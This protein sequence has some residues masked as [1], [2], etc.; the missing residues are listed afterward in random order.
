M[1]SGLGLYIMLGTDC[2]QSRVGYSL[3]RLCI[4]WRYITIS[5]TERLFVSDGRSCE[6]VR[7]MEFFFTKVASN[8]IRC[9][10]CSK[11]LAV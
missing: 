9:N 7:S 1:T 10:F 8:K 2:H 5:S 6:Q 11:E 4:V 3:R